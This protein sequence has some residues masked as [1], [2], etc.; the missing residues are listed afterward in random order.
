M[1]N[2]NEFFIQQRFDNYL[3]PASIIKIEWASDAQPLRALNL[4]KDKRVK[5]LRLL[6]L[7]FFQILFSFT[8][9]YF[10]IF[11]ASSVRSVRKLTKAT[12]TFAKRGSPGQWGGCTGTDAM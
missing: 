10:N 3:D 12:R 4:T 7:P 6:R 5:T 11:A 2:Y 8:V 1:T 9:E